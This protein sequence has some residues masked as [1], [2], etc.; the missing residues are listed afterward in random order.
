MVR[1]PA[2]PF[3]CAVLDSVDGEPH[4][5]GM[6]AKSKNSSSKLRTGAGVV[7]VLSLIPHVFCC[8]LP[9]V[10]AIMA[11]GSTVGLAAAMADNPLYRFVD[12]YH[13]WLL[14]VAIASVVVSGVVNFVAWRIDCHEASAL[15]DEGCHHGSCEPK[16]RTS[17][18]IFYL[19]LALLAVDVA[20]F[21]FE[22]KH[23][24]HDHSLETAAEHAVHAHE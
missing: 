15:D 24:L 23:G 13:A 12:Q 10:A 22:A 21:T 7:S 4:K 14:G 6:F 19:S 17:L 9:T 1:G 8:F 11:L 18:K 3:Y 2:G 16:K 5:V 20:W